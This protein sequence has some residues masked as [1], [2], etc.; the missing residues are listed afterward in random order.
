MWDPPIELGRLFGLAFFLVGSGQM[1]EWPRAAT[2]CQI[3]PMGGGI[4]CGTGRIR[5]TDR[6]N[7]CATVGDF[8]S[9]GFAV[10]T[11]V[12]ALLMAVVGRVPL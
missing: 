2:G 8:L 12:Q 3:L 10:V 6:S 4:G 1:R 9:S 5:I 7:H 11:G